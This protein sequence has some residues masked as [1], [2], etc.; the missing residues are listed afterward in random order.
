M[1]WIIIYVLSV[2]YGVSND[3]LNSYSFTFF[4]LG[5]AAMEF[6]SGIMLIIFLKNLNHNLD[7]SYNLKNNTFFFEKNFVKKF[8]QKKNW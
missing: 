2:F 7:F 6:C 4:I 3:E 1:L 5:F 8:F